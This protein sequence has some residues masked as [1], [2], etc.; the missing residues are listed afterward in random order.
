[1]DNRTIADEFFR[2]SY[3]FGI[4]A[5]GTIAQGVLYRAMIANNLSALGVDA[6]QL[7]SDFATA[8]GAIW[9]MPT[10]GE[11]GPAEGFGDYEYHESFATRLGLHYT[12]SREDAQ[13]QPGEDDF[14]NSQIRLS[15]GTR[16]FEPGAFGTDGRI[17]KATYRMMAA[18][19]GFKYRGFSLEGEYFWR[20]VDDFETVGFI[21]VTELFDHGFQLQTSA[22]LVRD[23][24]QLYGATSKVFGEYGDPWDLTVGLNW[25]P[26]ARRE[27]RVNV[28]GIYLRNS[29]VGG[30]SYPYLVGGNGWLFNTDFIITF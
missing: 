13:S 20:W 8:S 18:N 28:Q 3:S 6:A 10:T 15:D 2:A 16:I 30:T 9:W 11:Y 21:P 19:A 29:P 1:M 26:F 5:E 4:W 14:E 25:Y 17:N 23:R 27:M 22:M 12:Y 7:D 24:V